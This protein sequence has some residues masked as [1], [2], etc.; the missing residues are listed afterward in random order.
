MSRLEDVRRAVREALRNARENGYDMSTWTDMDV[1]MDMCRCDADLEGADP[2][3]VAALVG[4]M[5]TDQG[6]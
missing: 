2:A 6:E 4:T 3:I 1:A 5:R